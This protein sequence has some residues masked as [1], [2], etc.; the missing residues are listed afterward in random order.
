M[1]PPE[2][3][4]ACLPYPSHW[5]RSSAGDLHY[6]DEGQGQP[7]VCLHGNPDWLYSYRKVIGE[8][9]PDYRC[10][11][12]DHLGFGLSAKPQAAS[13][14][15]CAHADRL[16]EWVQELNL[17]GICLVLNDWSGPIGLALAQRYPERVKSLILMNTWMWPL[18]NYWLMTIFSKLMSGV[19]GR[20][21]TG[22]GNLFSSLLVWLAVYNKAAF[23]GQVHR[24]YQYPYPSSLDRIAQYT[25]PWFLKAA[26]GWLEGLYQNRDLIAHKKTAL[27]WGMRDP[28]FRFTFLKAWEEILYNPYVVKLAEAGHFPQEDQPSQVVEAIHRV[29]A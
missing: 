22:Y 24:C 14:H 27:V 26:S 23:S 20:L 16:A 4:S 12:L 9:L 29:M 6:L 18:D 13:Y 28:A 10:L 15:P 7:V 21:L 25:M 19:S 1:P 5:F 17:W 8:L 3:S 2:N 11:A